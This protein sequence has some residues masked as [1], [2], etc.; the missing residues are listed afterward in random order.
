MQIFAKIPESAMT[1]LVPALW[2]IG[3]IC[4]APERAHGGV[5]S[6]RQDICCLRGR[7]NLSIRTMSLR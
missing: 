6:G 2:M 7:N 4:A 3:A 5:C 1:M